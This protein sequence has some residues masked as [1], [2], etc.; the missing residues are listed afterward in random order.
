MMMMAAPQLVHS[1]TVSYRLLPLL[2][3]A[4]LSTFDKFDF[5]PFLFVF[6]VLPKTRIIIK[7][8]YIVLL[9]CVIALKIREESVLPDLAALPIGILQRYILYLS[10]TPTITV[11]WM[12]VDCCSEG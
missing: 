7:M 6:S 5:M 1:W 2:R 9:C 11:S 12:S 8:N 3:L 10:V 4:F